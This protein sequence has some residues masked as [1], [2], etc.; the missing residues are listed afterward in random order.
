MFSVSRGRK[1]R[2]FP[3]PCA[4]PLYKT[5]P[6]SLRMKD[7]LP[8]PRCFFRSLPA[9]LC[10]SHGPETR[11]LFLSPPLPSLPGLTI[12]WMEELQIPMLAGVQRQSTMHPAHTGVS[13]KRK[14]CCWRSGTVQPQPEDLAHLSIFLCLSHHRDSA[15]RK[16]SLPTS[17]LCSDTVTVAV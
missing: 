6:P 11:Q 16:S 7:T 4:S 3:T 1:P 12:K 2:Y 15:T 14:S 8:Q 10:F 17:L 5:V 9:P 13:S